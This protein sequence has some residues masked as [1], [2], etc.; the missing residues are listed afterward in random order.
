M[1]TLGFKDRGPFP[2]EC[3]GNRAG[4]KR[5]NM[6]AQGGSPKRTDGGMDLSGNAT[7]SRSIGSKT[8]AESPNS[9]KQSRNRSKGY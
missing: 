3:T 1:T 2:D 4:K 7:N 9:W 6:A 8:K 5:A